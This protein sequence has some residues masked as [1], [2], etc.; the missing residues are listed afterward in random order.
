MYLRYV[1]MDAQKPM[2]T[3][4]S[5]LKDTVEPEVRSE[6]IY[7]LSHL[8]EDMTSITKTW[9]DVWHL[10][11][12]YHTSSKES[13]RQHN[14]LRIQNELKNAAKEFTFG[15]YGMQSNCEST[16]TIEWMEMVN[17]DEAWALTV[18]Y[19]KRVWQDV[20]DS[21]LYIKIS[22]KLCEKCADAPISHYL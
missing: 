20:D 9:P 16:P 13:E 6:L 3:L 7:R 11:Q 17:R 1:H 2:L 14:I 21:R 5:N 4:V 12:E 19:L 8:N 15:L 22:E 10:V 18:A